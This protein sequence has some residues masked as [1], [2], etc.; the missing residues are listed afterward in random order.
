MEFKEELVGYGRK[1]EFWFVLW[2]AETL[3]SSRR[4]ERQSHAAAC[5]VA[6]AWA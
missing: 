2:V 1:P 3:K 6:Q 5:S 4:P